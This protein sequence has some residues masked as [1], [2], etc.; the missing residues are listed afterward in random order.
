MSIPAFATKKRITVLMLVL[1]TLVLGGMSY[2]RTPVDLLPNMQFPMAAVV[3]SFP[4]AAPQEIETLVTRP[5]EATLATVSN[6]REVSSTSSEGQAVITISF[7]WG[8][9]MDFAALEMREKVDLAKRFFPAEV[10]TP[11][12]LKFDPS[13]MPIMVTDIGS[14]KLTGAQMRDL[15]DR[16]LAARIERIPGVASVAVSGGQQSMIEISVDP[17]KSEEFG[18][19]LA[20]ITGSLRTA[21]MSMPGGSINVEGE[22]VLIRSVGQL[23]SMSEIENLVVGMRTVRTVTTSAPVAPR[24]PM[25]PGVV[26]PP[27]AAGTQVATRLEPVFLRQVATVAEV[28]PFAQSAMRLNAMPAVSLRM[29]KESGANTVLVANLIHA[30]LEQM[31][32][33]YPDLSIVASQDQS[34]FI[35][36]AIG[37]VGSNALFGGAIAVLVL[38]VFL[39]SMISTLIIALAVPVSVVATFALIYFGG[40]T[41]NLM[42]LMGLALG[43]GMLVDNS[44][45]V[46]ENIFRLQE[47]GVDSVV[48]AR[49]GAEEVA[50]AISASTLTTVAVFL[51]VAFVGGFTGLM[52]RELALT[53]SFSLLASLAVAL[54]VVPMLAA[55]LL[56][57]RPKI[58]LER[59]ARLSP[60]QRSLKW[61]L[62]KKPLVILVTLLL[63]G[64]S[65]LT[66]PHLGGEFIPPMDQ[67]EMRMTVT[68]PSSSSFQETDRVASEVESRLL[69]RG[70]VLSVATSIGATTG[71]RGAIMG[72][73]GARR[74]RAV[75]TVVLQP[76]QRAD[77]LVKELNEEY[78]T[79]VGAT[80]VAESVAG[81]AAGMGGV[82][83]PVQVNLSGPSLEGLRL[84]AD[85]IKGAL[86]DVEGITEVSD[87]MGVGSAEFVIRVKRTEAAELGVSPVAVASAVR[88]AFQGETVAR[89]SRD[90]REVDVTVKLAL[91]ARQNV[92]SLENLMVAA[93]QGR[94]VRLNE[95][96]IVERS[97][98][99]AAIRRMS[100]QR[101]VSIS[102]SIAERDL[103]SVSRDVEA[104]LEALSL[105]DD[106]SYEIAG[107]MSEMREAFDGLILALI[108]AVVLVYMVMAAQFESLL[109]P[110]IVMFSLPLAV[111]GVLFGLFFTGTTLSVPSIMG[112]IVLAGIVV[113]NAIVLVDYINQLRERGKGVDEAI[114]EAAGVRLR[115]ILM[116]TATTA[117]ALV[118]LA[119]MPGSGAEMQQPLGIAVIGGLTVSTLLTLYL[120]PVAYDLVTL[121]R[122]NGGSQEIV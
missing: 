78:A 25:P 98:G 13:M 65:L 41:L 8:T 53:V 103:Q 95:V 93:P 12:V 67:G 121:R 61:A 58:A 47:E 23:V 33:D 26:L 46:L 114:V 27:A 28:N 87:N 52:F 74:N 36:Q 40:L 80:V 15:A 42:T 6:M 73:G 70:E 89:V 110:F 5:L 59:R 82:G 68:L 118:P 18:V 105:P 14:S 94:I 20:Q 16:T 79:F 113:N 115:P 63:L 112:V 60:Y 75:M 99:P 4:G 66:Y 7:N 31:R 30:E 81:L 109:Y 10:G 54:L 50:M 84:H 11:T 44:I 29:Q 106:Y 72:G 100:N 55:T 117:L 101:V 35:E 34:R 90:G 24:M 37:S 91:E 92:A 32:I 96:A 19:T 3:V 45:V 22:E 108:L 76:G 9:N 104:A 116:T 51:P 43:I 102:A 39:K 120:I 111:I 85:Q 62:K 2:T 38:F 71:T 69:A 77:T 97:V 49:R 107:E 48:A 21:S 57:A 119:M 64:G 56:R 83:A 88:T 17:V 86:L 122:R 1:V